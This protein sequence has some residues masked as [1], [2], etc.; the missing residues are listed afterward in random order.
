MSAHKNLV[1]VFSI[2]MVACA[3]VPYKLSDNAMAI[4]SK[5]SH[6]EALAI[7]HKHLQPSDRQSGL[8]GVSPRAGDSVTP[9]TSQS[10]L[11]STKGN[12]ITYKGIVAKVRNVNTTGNVMSGT[13]QVNSVYEFDEGL[14]TMDLTKIGYI[15][16]AENTRF[17]EPGN[18]RRLYRNNEQGKLVRSVEPCPAGQLI[19]LYAGGLQYGQ[20]SLSVWV[21]VAADKLDSLLAALS[22][23][24]PSVTIRLGTDTLGA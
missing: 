20:G 14:F 21:H 2:F 3:A 24:S 8:C 17:N 10:K 18:P 5:M 15:G 7:V 13:A 11:V 4:R 22:Y 12:T 1:A 9:G 23:L 6:E 19:L 16:V